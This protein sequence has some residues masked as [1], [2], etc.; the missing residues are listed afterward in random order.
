MSRNRSSKEK[1]PF[2]PHETRSETGY[3][4]GYI[5]MTP[6]LY[7]SDSMRDLKDKARIVFQDMKFIAKNKTE[8]IYTQKMGMERLNLSK[9][10]YTSSI[11]Q[12][13]DVG[14]IERLPRGCYAPAKYKFSCEWKKYYSPNRDMFTGE[15][16]YK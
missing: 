7:Y 15:Y 13:I 9:G 3:E 14:L 10:G 16:S 12:L 2:L 5:R 1:S 11:N 8:V 4:K 6:S